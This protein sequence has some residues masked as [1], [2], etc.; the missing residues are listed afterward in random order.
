[1]FTRTL[2][3]AF[4]LFTSVAAVGCAGAPATP[5]AAA[6][7]A[8]VVSL[9]TERQ[10]RLE[11]SAE[12]RAMLAST[13]EDRID[14]MVPAEG[15]G[16]ISVALADGE[17]TLRTWTVDDDT[18][19]RLGTTITQVVDPSSLT[20]ASACVR[21]IPIACP[22]GSPAGSSCMSCTTIPCPPKPTK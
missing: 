16:P 15:A 13:I 19:A 8:L 11:G 17:G 20:E 10:V 9:G 7:D 12:V 6:N 21:C 18:V 2:S 22:A 5:N 1:M 14:A 3:I 4:L